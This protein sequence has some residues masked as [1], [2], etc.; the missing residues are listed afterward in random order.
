MDKEG[1]GKRIP[2]QKYELITTC[3][4]ALFRR[5]HKGLSKNVKTKILIT[6]IL[7]KRY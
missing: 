4:Y 6:Y 1:F 7:R 5:I 2:K 3:S